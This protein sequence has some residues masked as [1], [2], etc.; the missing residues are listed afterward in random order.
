MQYYVNPNKAISCYHTIAEAIAA[1]PEDP[2]EPAEIVLS[3]GT[4]HEKVEIRRS[5]LTITGEGPEA[6]VIVHDDYALMP[7]PDGSKCGTFRSYTFFLDGDHNRMNHLTIRNNARPRRKVGQTVALYV[8]GDDFRA[9]DCCFDSFQDTLFTGPLPPKAMTPGGF[10]G[11]KEFDKRAK[12]RQYY[13]DCHIRGDVDFIFGSAIA[14]FEHCL[15]ESLDSGDLPESE[16][17]DSSIYGYVTA[18]ST[19]EGYKYGYVFKDC[20]FISD[21]CPA[22]SV[23]LGRPWREFAKTVL[24]GC[25]LGA[26]IHKDGFF[27][28]NKTDARETIYYAEY[29]SSGPGASDDTRVEYVHHL[30][31]KEAAKYTRKNVL[32]F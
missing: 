1:L 3:A 16:K 2:K 17:S 9:E 21:K 7:M 4:F 27:D 12:S 24:I 29:E 5:N 26:H 15:I 31:E 32:G 8:D 22:G 25:R 19:P 11:P 14:Y 23:Y 18:A 20:D 6:T 30:T 13:K 10:T 28:W